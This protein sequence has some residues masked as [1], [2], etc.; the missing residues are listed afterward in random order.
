MRSRP[1]SR[2]S[3]QFLLTVVAFCA[4]P[5]V[6]TAAPRA[7]PDGELPPDS[8]LAA[9]KDL[10]GYFPFEPAKSPAAWHARSNQLRRQLQVAV[11]LW[12]LPE[13]TPLNPIVHGLRDMGDYT[14]EKVAIEPRP[15]Y[16]LTGSLYR[17]KRLKS[18]APGVLSPHGH[19]SQGRF[20]DNGEDNTAEEVKSGAERFADGG[21]SPLQSRMVQ[22]AR[23]GCVVFHYDMVGYADCTQVS[24]EVAH[25]FAKQRPNMNTREN[26]GFYSPRAESHLQSIMGLQTW[27]N[28]RALDFVLSLPDVDGSR[29]GITGASGGGTQTFMMGALDPR[30][31]VLFPAVMVSTAMQGGC[32]CENSSLL[33]VGTGNIEFAALAAPKPYGMTGANDWTV[34]M[35]TKGFP[36]LQKHF[37]ML[38]AKENVELTALNHFGHNYNA[39]SREAMYGW[40]NKHLKIGYGGP[41][42]DREYKRLTGEDLTVWDD[43]HP[44]PKGGEDFERKLLRELKEDA[45]R[46]IAKDPDIARIGIE[47]VLGRR[48]ADVGTVEFEFSPNEAEAK[49]DKGT[50]WEMTGLLHNRTHEEA[51]P[52]VFFHPKENWNGDVLIW[53]HD[54]GKAGLFDPSENPIAPVKMLIDSG[55]SLAGID[56]LFQGEFNAGGQSLEKTRRVGNP[57]EAACYTFGYN[58]SVFVQRVHDLLSTIAFVRDHQYEPKRILVAGGS[59]V[60]PIVAAAGTQAIGAVHGFAIDTGGLRFID[61]DDLHSPDF[62]PGGAKYGD[63]PGM[64]ARLSPT[65][66]LLADPNAE[67]LRAGY[68]A[69]HAGEELELTESGETFPDA[70]AKWVVGE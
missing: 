13:R 52:I 14:I 58:H 39:P 23:M 30:P 36:E 44:R 34:D 1:N 11:G 15:G 4:A 53:A 32:T 60:G 24:Y 70:V 27:N 33:R 69:A 35:S 17:P 46:Q 57:R 8:R 16:Y 37:A 12:P 64:L 41:L 55:V 59:G 49:S 22:L 56:L 26:W 67:F 38:G 10:N 6:S 5:P 65:P 51:L 63:L 29:I 20:Y 61:I 9:L 21:R 19:W 66:M 28:M 31:A 68:T 18:R 54:K 48:L 42:E 25:R 7:F 50:H 3:F 40:F 45:E 43:A 2:L 62:V 47:A